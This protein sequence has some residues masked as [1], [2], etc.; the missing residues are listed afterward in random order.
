MLRPQ[1][2]WTKSRPVMVWRWFMLTFAVRSLE[3]LLRSGTVLRSQTSEAIDPSHYHRQ[4]EGELI[5]LV[6]VTSDKTTDYSICF[7]PS[8][9]HFHIAM[10]SHWFYVIQS[11]VHRTI[12]I[13]LLGKRITAKEVLLLFLGLSNPCRGLAWC[14]RSLYKST[15][16]ECR[17]VILPIPT[18]DPQR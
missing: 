10:T 18:I 17:Q 6:V 13:K 4:I 7:V 15:Y 5:Q 2:P 1:S 12:F 16:R 3:A 8:S 11:L 9:P 14:F